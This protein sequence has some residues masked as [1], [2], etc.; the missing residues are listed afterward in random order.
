M[1]EASLRQ[2]HSFW[3]DV[4]GPFSR[5]VPDGC[6]L[7]RAL[8]DWSGGRRP[9]R[10]RSIELAPGDSAPTL[11]ALCDEA[12]EDAERRGWVLVEEETAPSESVHELEGVLLRIGSSRVPVLGGAL[13]VLSVAFDQPWPLDAGPPVETSEMFQNLV[14]RL[15]EL[16]APPERLAKEVIVDVLD[17]TRIDLLRERVALESDPRLPTRFGKLGFMESGDAPGLWTSRTATP[18]HDIVATVKE[19]HANVEVEMI[20]RRLLD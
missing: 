12:R 11:D 13:P 5:V 2:I 16:S 20:K 8:D 18:T 7:V 3:P 15:L 19:T 1:D 4:S 10:R 17:F 9:V 14:R 6:F